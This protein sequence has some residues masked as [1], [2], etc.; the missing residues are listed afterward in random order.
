MTSLQNTANET[1]YVN[2]GLCNDN[3]VNED[4]Q[5]ISDL[6]DDNI[7]NADLL[8]DNEVQN[9]LIDSAVTNSSLETLMWDQN[10][11]HTLKACKS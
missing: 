4:K 3:V 11:V 6:F 7:A 1:V 10:E 5:D 8:N 2:K 9:D